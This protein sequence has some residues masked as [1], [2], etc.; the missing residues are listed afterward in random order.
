MLWLIVIFCFSS[1]II[2]I[3]S[4]ALLIVPSR[5]F[6]HWISIGLVRCIPATHSFIDSDIITIIRCHCAHFFFA[7]NSL[8]VRFCSMFCCCRFIY[9]QSVSQT[10]CHSLSLSLRV[11]CFMSHLR[12]HN[13]IQLLFV[14]VLIFRF[15]VLQL[16][17]DND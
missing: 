12:T 14:C 4:A 10:Y 15:L 2:N 5:S 13:S 1:C 3:P 8:S 6:C 17:I 16:P 11:L 9:W 7:T